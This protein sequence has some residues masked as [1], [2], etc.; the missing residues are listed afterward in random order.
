[1][2]KKSYGRG[3]RYHHGALR[4]ALIDA[5]L[6]GLERHG[7]G[8]LSLRSL[9]AAVGVSHAAPTHH[10]RT[11]E[12]LRSALAAV[13]Y[14]RFAAALGSARATAPADAAA[15]MR[16][17]E[18]AYLAFARGQPA[19]F[20]LMFTK[21]LLDW[22]DANLLQKAGAAQTQLSEI[23]APAAEK[24]GLEDAR[25]R[26]ALEY[27]VWSTV[28]GQAHL[29][30]DGQFGTLPGDADLPGPQSGCPDLAALLFGPDVGA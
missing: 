22:T 30:I 12:G 3:E 5:G 9:A 19:L 26:R 29:A 1:M 6:A 16:A 14:E 17:A 8:Q 13:G 18:R 15:Q 7:L 24:L 4:E 23:C 2:Q 10:F 11:I 20:R 27:L 21:E 28:H 25:A